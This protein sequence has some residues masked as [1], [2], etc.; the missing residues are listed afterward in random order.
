PHRHAER[1]IDG[2]C[3][4][5]E[6]MRVTARSM[7]DAKGDDKLIP[8]LTHGDSQDPE[9][10]DVPRLTEVIKGEENLAVLNAWLSQYKFQRPLML[11]P[12]T[13]KERLSILRKAF[14][15]TLEDPIFLAQAKKS[16]LIINYVSGEE[17]EKFVDQILAISPKTK[18]SSSS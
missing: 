17:I 12:G 15:A 3:W 1:E 9:V 7:L 5:W 11:P 10:K 18:E 2:A 4:S 14:K 8:F 16:K 13:P 6:S